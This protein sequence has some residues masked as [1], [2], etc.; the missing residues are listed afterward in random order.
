MELVDTRDL[1]SLAYV[2]M[3]VRIPPVLPSK[4]E[5]YPVEC[6]LGVDTLEVMVYNRKG[7]LVN[8]RDLWRNT[9]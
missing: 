5:K 6:P 2:S 3:R 9:A 8:I 7:K 1:K 4:I